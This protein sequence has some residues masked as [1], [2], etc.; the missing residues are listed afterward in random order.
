MIHLLGLPHTDTVAVE[1]D[2]C[3]FTGKIRKLA[4]MLTDQGHPVTLYGSERNDAPVAEHVVCVT[5]EMRRRWFGD[6]TWATRVFDRW[7]PTDPCWAES[8]AAIIKALAERL[9]PGDIIACPIGSVQRAVTDTYPGTLAVESG[10]GYEGSWLPHRC[11]ESATWQHWTYGAQ[12]ITDGRYYDVVIPN[13][14]V[15]ADFTFRDDHDGYLL[16]LG[17]HTARKGLPVVQEIAKH[18]RVITAGQGGPLEGCEY[19]GVVHGK[20][21]AD[22]L[23]GARA[24]LAPTGYVEP[25]GGCSVEAQMSGTPVIASPWGGFVENVEP[26]VTGFL[27]HT[28]GELLGAVESCDELDRR[29]IHDRAVAR[30]SLD[31]IA[32][33][34]DRWFTRL[35]TLHGAG[36]YEGAPT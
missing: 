1:W 13:A 31:A 12:G 17:R 34:Y 11:F 36:W 15:P 22:L 16:F 27:P 6:E 14:V 10:I 4:R 23:A 7:D 30:F 33:Q 26:G 28:L 19:A 2:H 24:L 9:A 3:A 32:P 29:E 18:H 20:D 35:A 21:R 8:N 5:D 25:W